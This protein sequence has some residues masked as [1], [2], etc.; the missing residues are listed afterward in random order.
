MNVNCKDRERIL[1]EE[2]S[3]GLAALR[4]HAQDCA[5]CAR[6]LRI[7]SEISAAAQQ[8]QK[9]WESPA[10]WARIR[11]SLI[12]ESQKEGT[13]APRGVSGGLWQGIQLHWQTAAAALVLVIVS[14]TATWMLVRHTPQSQIGNLAS[15]TKTPDAQKRLLTDQA[16]R[17]VEN[18]EQ[19]LEK[20]IE[21]LSALADPK[22]E[23]ASTPLSVNYREKLLVLDAAIAELKANEEKNP[24]NAQ[25]RQELLSIYLE[26]E[27]TL[28]AVVREN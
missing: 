10:L 11:E 3:R 23:H 8:M 16:L 14:A 26:K 9:S 12:L 7:W 18:N 15:P 28:K 22:L 24:L 6:E 4:L 1:R 13:R 27:S 2:E 21:K 19:A 17:E 5:E 20:S 25:L